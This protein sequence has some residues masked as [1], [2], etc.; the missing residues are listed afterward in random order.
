M[1][2]EKK[3]FF[4]RKTAETITSRTDL[5]LITRKDRQVWVMNHLFI[6]PDQHDPHEISLLMEEVI[7]F[8]KQTNYQ[9]WPLDPIA[10]AYFKKHPELNQLWYHKPY[11]F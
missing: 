8:V 10:I 6:N 2:T 4:T 7:T 3:K 1:K 5:D 9:I 11:N